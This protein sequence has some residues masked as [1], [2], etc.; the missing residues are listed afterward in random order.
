VQQYADRTHG[1]LAEIDHVPAPFTAQDSY[2]YGQGRS[3]AGVPI[4]FG[5]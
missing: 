5:T 3:S 1:L 4:G 2:S